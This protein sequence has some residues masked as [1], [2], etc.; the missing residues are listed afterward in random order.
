MKSVGIICEYNPFHNGHEY[1]INKVKELYPNH[2]IILILNGNFTQRGGISLIDKWKKTEIALN[3]VDLVVELPFVFGTQGADIFSFAS[4][5]LLK[6]LKVE[7]VVFGSEC[8][9]VSKLEKL[10]SVQGSKEYNNMVKKYLNE[11]YNYPSSLSK[12]L[13][14]ICGES[15]FSPN[16]LLALGYVRNLI[17]SGIKPVS[18]K[19]TNDYLNSEITGDITS[20]TSIR[21]AL[22]NGKDVYDF[23]PLCSYKYLN[24]LVF[25]SDFFKF[26]KYKIIS[27]D[28]SVYQTVDEGIENRLKKY[29]YVSNSLEEFI[30]NIKTKRYTYN[31]I[32]RMLVH[33]LTGFTKKEAS[34][35]NDIEYIRILG[36]NKSGQN[37]LNVI[38]KQ[39]DIPIITNYKKGNW[40]LEVEC[41][42]S[43]IY[44]LIS[45]NKIREFERKVIKKDD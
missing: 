5:Q 19:R 28:I 6:Y 42:V 12:A 11:G 35:I 4:I 13:Y 29:I 45:G 33:I 44:N 40:M 27:E 18:I 41:R 22:E 21:N 30:N 31:R 23:V 15:V 17:G 14:K 2:I 36:F 7:A 37:Y 10:A 39:C 3:Y 43:D 24:D 38:K 32:C 9:D 16:D 26:L 34:K 25:S 1:H 20:G 8:D